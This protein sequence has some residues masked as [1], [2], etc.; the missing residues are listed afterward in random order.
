MNKSPQASKACKHSV[1]CS[2]YSQRWIDSKLALP[3]R[4]MAAHGDSESI[5][6]VTS[7]LNSEGKVYFSHCLHPK[8]HIKEA[9]TGFTCFACKQRCKGLL[10]S[11]LCHHCFPVDSRSPCQFLGLK[12]LKSPGL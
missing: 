10:V 1:T 12:V 4:V 7:S 8:R 9:T 3:C 5:R 2:L 11:A 6:H